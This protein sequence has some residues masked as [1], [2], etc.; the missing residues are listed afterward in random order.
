MMLHVF[1]RNSLRSL[2][3]ESKGLGEEASKTASEVIKIP[4]K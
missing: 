3:E 1:R 4:I 2:T